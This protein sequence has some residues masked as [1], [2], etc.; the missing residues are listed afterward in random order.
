M[1]PLPFL[2]S[3]SVCRVVGRHV[4]LGQSGTKDLRKH[5]QTNVHTKSQQGTSGMKPLHSYF[6][7]VRNESVIEA[8]VKFGFFVGEHHLAFLLADH[9][10][11]LFRSMFPDSSIAKDFK[12]G[13]TKATAVLKIIAQDVQQKLL[14]ALSD[15]K[16]FSLQMD[17]ITDITVTQQAG[18]MLR[19]FDNSIGKVK[20]I[21]Y[22]LDKVEHADAVHLFE[23]IDH[24]F[25]NNEILMYDNLVGLGIDG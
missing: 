11:R 25:H 8:E 2:L 3:V 24:H 4:S 23:N 18:I 15:S 17:E 5:E 22:S 19:Y 12:C 16:Y 6:G 7:P 10:N 13:R 9:C 14:C 1:F 21:F 20:C